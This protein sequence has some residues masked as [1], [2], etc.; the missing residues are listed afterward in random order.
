ML[1]AR[2]TAS[3]AICA[4]RPAASEAQILI[5]IDQ[6]EELFGAADPEQSARFLEILSRAMAD[7]LPFM[8]VMALRSDY[9]GQLQSATHLTA[10]FEEFSLGPMPLA[11]VPQII[12]GPAR[13]AG[14]KVDDAFVQQAARDA[15]TEDALPLLAFALRELLDRSGGDNYLSLDEYKALGDDK[16]GLTPLEN[17]VRRAADD[18]LAEAKPT[19]EELAALREAFVPAMVRVNDQGDYVRRP[20]RLD[21]LPAKSHPLLERLAKA[22]LLIVR[23]GGDARMVE[24]AHEALLRKWPQLRKWLDEARE[25]LIGK[26]QLEQ[27]LRDW[28]QAAAGR[29]GRRA[30]DR[31]QAQ[32]RAR[33]A[34]LASAA[35]DRAGAR[36]HPGQHRVPPRQSNAKRRS[37]GVTSPAARSRRR[38]WSPALRLSA[39][40]RRGE[41]A[42]HESK[43]GGTAGRELGSRWSGPKRKR[44]TSKA[45]KESAA[46]QEAD[47]KAL[48]QSAEAQASA[49]ANTAKAQA[50][51]AKEQEKTAQAQA[52]TADELI[53]YTWID[54]GARQQEAARLT[55]VA[56]KLERKPEELLP[57]TD[58]R[59]CRIARKPRSSS[60][61]TSTARPTWIP[62][63][64][65]FTVRFAA[66]SV[67]TRCRRSRA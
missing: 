20:A 26:Q 9:L 61:A 38:S 25:F 58:L 57:N 33:L 62:D 36:L 7:D 34:H 14:L 31:P 10:R 52:R 4:S 13:V 66:S 28:E 54:L 51:T 43:R 63:S 3:P 32:P 22:R 39:A 49:Q 48:K 23:Q 5:P 29:Q 19:D 24:V 6:A 40:S 30:V 59:Q 17:A 15:E 21:D 46:R 64:A 27:D 67:S 45:I 60:P 65:T 35:T 41:A 11:R 2:S 18:V 12:Q 56:K 16:A 8:A 55:E 47:A 50:E 44:T 53:R 1:R 37:C 42:R